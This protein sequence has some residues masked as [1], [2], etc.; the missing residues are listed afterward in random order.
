MLPD[1]ARREIKVSSRRKI[2]L[3]FPADK[4]KIL[5]E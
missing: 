4:V 5:R 1:P 2:Q 3:Y